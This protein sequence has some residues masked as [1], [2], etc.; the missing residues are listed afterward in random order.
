[1]RTEGLD[2]AVPLFLKIMYREE[3]KRALEYDI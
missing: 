2:F 1:M 3:Q